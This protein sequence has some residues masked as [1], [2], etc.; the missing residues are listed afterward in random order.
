MRGAA[1]WP[2]FAV[3]GC[4][5]GPQDAGT[6]GGRTRD[7][8]PPGTCDT[9]A[10]W[11]G[12]P[13]VGLGPTQETAAVAVGGKIYVLGGFLLRDSLEVTAAVQVFDTATCTWSEGPAMPKPVHHANAAVLDGTIYVLGAM[14]G[15]EFSTIGD[16]WSWNPATDAAWAIRAPISPSAARGSAITGALDGKLYVA[17][18]LRDGAVTDVS[19]YDPVADAWSDGPALPAPRDHGCGGEVGGKLYVIGGRNANIGSTA[20]TVYELAPG[21]AAWQS[22]TAMPTARGGTG[23]GVIDGRIIVVGGEG[24]PAAGSRGVFPQVEAYDAAA[25]TWEALPPMR[26][27]RHGM[28]AAAWGGRLYVPGGADRQAFGPVDTH[29][30]LTP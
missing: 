7:A 10:P 16:T 3:L 26:T 28:G 11:A 21:G 22:R 4:G 19:I 23:C 12:A 27:P 1:W 17:G 13:A 25:D 2:L 20:S 24:N 8:P 29:E 5:D 9:T 15:P 6:D 30:I 14:Q 18:G